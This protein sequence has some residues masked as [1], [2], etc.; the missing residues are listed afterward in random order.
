MVDYPNDWELCKLDVVTSESRVRAK[1]R[2]YS[3]IP[4]LGVSNK[5]L[6]LTDSV[7]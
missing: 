4:V 2:E 6:V 1:S 5:I 7:V 3:E